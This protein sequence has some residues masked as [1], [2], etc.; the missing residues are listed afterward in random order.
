MKYVWKKLLVSGKVAFYNSKKTKI[1][2][3]SNTK[4]AKRDVH[5]IYSIELPLY[6]IVGIY[7]V[8]GEESCLQTADFQDMKNNVR[9]PVIYSNFDEFILRERVNEVLVTVNP[10]L[11]DNGVLK[12]LINN[13]IGISFEIGGLFSFQAEDQ[14]VANLATNK[15]LHVGDFSFTPRQ[16]FYFTIKRL[17]DILCG[18]IGVFVLVPVTLCVK[19]AY[20]FSGDTARIFYRQRRVGKDGKLIYIWKYRSMVPNAGEILEEMLK[21]ENYRKEWEENQ[22][23]ENDPR[24]TKVGAVL[25]KTSIDEL[26]Q[27]I[28]VLKGDMSLVGDRVILGHTKKKPV[29]MRL[30]AA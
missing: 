26:P 29:F 3:I 20:L 25:R 5:S 22:K 1:F 17:F 18:L 11:I 4:N 2:I 13:G 7:L 28:N 21:D 9:I 27:L 12:E 14:F 23:F 15:V 30:S 16:S 10:S 19:L 6:D 24:I 8:D